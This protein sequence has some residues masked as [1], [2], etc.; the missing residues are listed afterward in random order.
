MK[1]VS[2]GAFIQMLVLFGF[3]GESSVLVFLPMFEVGAPT[4]GPC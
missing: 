3:D 2:T 4:F 1:T